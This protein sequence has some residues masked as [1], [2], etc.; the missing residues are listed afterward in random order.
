M[1]KVGA[2]SKVLVPAVTFPS[3]PLS[4]Q[5]LGANVILAD[6][7]VTRWT[8][9][10]EI[11]LRAAEKIKFDAVMPV[12][13]Y[14]VPVP[15]EGW[16]RFTETTGIPV[17]ID[18]AAAIETQLIPKQGLVAHSLHATKPFGVGEGGLLVG[19]SV[20]Q[21]AAT[22]VYSNFGTYD[23][24][25]V[26]EGSNTK[27]SE[28]HAAVALQQV[29]RWEG[30]KTSRRTV[31]EMFRHH[32]QVLGEHVSLQ[33]DIDKAVVSSLMLRFK[34]PVAAEILARGLHDKIAFHRMYLP[35]LYHHPHFVGLGMIDADGVQ[36]SADAD[37]QHKVALMPNSEMMLAHIIGVPFH[38]FLAEND[39][40]RVIDVLGSFCR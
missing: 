37:Y 4:A 2:G 39:I 40:L 36:V 29:K 10:P 12:A 19:R 14:G 11:A 20:Q 18:A 15:V 16:D 21:I 26:S 38:P 30:I 17:I 33:P 8:L 27:M 1:L 22:R 35:P 5:L 25:T 28:F 7:D 9:T 23:R 6:V 13:L 31:F 34:K 32:L 24:V 3:S